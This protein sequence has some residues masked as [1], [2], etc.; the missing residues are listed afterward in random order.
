MAFRLFERLNS[1]NGRLHLRVKVPLIE[2]L[3][4]FAQRAHTV[5]S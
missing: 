2:R 5:A 1:M 3:A 4:S